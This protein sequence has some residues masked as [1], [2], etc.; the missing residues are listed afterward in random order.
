MNKIEF[1]SE[2]RGVLS[3]DLP[4]SEVISNIRY[5][6]G[7]IDNKSL[8][9]NEYEVIEQL[10]N[11]RLI[12]KTI[13]NTYKISHSKNKDT[14]YNSTSYKDND[15]EDMYTKNET[16][17]NRSQ[18]NNKFVIS[19]EGKWYQKLFLGLILLVVLAIILFVGQ[20]AIKLFF[21]FGIP[22]LILY[23]GFKFI[24]NIFRRR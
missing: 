7:Y 17:Y 9:S 6:E 24:S 3:T 2:L 22:L 5:Y 4:D 8:E 12:A 20:L 15:K 16:S 23:F 10:G 19:N 13:I 14:H 1:I 11:P 18:K 21:N